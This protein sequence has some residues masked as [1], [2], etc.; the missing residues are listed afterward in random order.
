[1]VPCYNEEDNVV[2]MS[3]A[4]VKQLEAMDNYDY[5]I[6]FI[7]NCSHDNTRDLLRG[8][9]EKNSKIKAIFNTKN[10]GQFNSPYYG[11]C[12]TTGDCTISVCC[13]FQD[14]VEMIPQFVREWE[15]GHK[16]VIGIKTKS[17]ES[18]VMYAIRGAYYYIFN[19][20]TDVEHIRQFTGF[21]LYDKSFMNIL[22]AV[23]DPVPYFRGLVAEYA[24]ERKEIP[25]TQPKR[26]RGKSN[27]NLYSLYDIGIT[28]LTTYSKAL[29][30]LTILVGGLCSCLSFLVAIGYFIYKLLNWNTFSAGIAPLVIGMFLLGG[31]QLLFIGVMGEY[32]LCINERTK[33]RPLVVEEER[34]NFESASSAE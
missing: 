28:G 7:D 8:I 2:P 27:N 9:C 33:N 30:R 31:V 20:L 11:I 22:R 18:P 5:E 29:M 16:V 6:V 21:G 23:H 24:K 17:K 3:E 10:F 14:P 4:L 32:I 25:Y 1:M 26:E 15:N 19:K 34:L 12:Q 13:D